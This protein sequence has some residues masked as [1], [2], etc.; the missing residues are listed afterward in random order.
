V[1]TTS[2][3]RGSSET[4]REESERGEPVGCTKSVV[5]SAPQRTARGFWEA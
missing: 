2:Q 5:N 4:A 1:V 3:L